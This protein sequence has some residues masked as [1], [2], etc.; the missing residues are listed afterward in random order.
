[1]GTADMWCIDVYGG[2]MWCIDVYGGDMWGIDIYGG[3][4]PTTLKKK[5]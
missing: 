1:V 2:D 3:R 5:E 4:I